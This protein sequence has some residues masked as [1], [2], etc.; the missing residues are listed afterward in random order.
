MEERL[1]VAIRLRDES[2]IRRYKRA[3]LFYSDKLDETW[4]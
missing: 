1:K 3:I 4:S 2:S